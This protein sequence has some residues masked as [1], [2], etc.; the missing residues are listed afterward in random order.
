MQEQGRFDGLVVVEAI[1]GGGPIGREKIGKQCGET[2]LSDI[3]GRSGGGHQHFPPVIAHLN[4]GTQR[5]VDLNRRNMVRGM[6]RI[7]VYVVIDQLGRERSLRLRDQGLNS[8]S[9]RIEP[10]RRN[11]IARERSSNKGS[12]GRQPLRGRIV[13]R[14]RNDRVPQRVRSYNFVGGRR[15]GCAKIPGL[16]LCC[17]N[18]EQVSG[19]SGG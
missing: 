15:L 16:I 9:D 8:Q 17:G 14:I 11:D 12:I 2:I 3:G 6:D 18:G 19:S 1:A 7:W 4:L 5:V 10:A 13:N